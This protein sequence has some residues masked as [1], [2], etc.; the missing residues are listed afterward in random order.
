MLVLTSDRG[1]D[2]PHFAVLFGLGMIGAEIF[3]SL[4]QHG[5]TVI[6]RAS[7]DWVGPA[8]RDRQLAEL[9]HD[10]EAARAFDALLSVVWSAGATDFS[11]GREALE[12]E[13]EHFAAVLNLV[14]R[15]ARESTK[16]AASFHFISS[17]GGLFEGQRLVSGASKPAPKRPY[18]ALKLQQEREL[19]QHASTLTVRIYRPSSVYGHRV[20]RNPGKGLINNLLVNAGKG[21]QTILD[22]KLL[23]LR[24]YVYAGDVGRFVADRLVTDAAGCGCRNYL[25]ATG[26]PASILEISRLVERVS[27]KPVLFR[28]D[29]SFGNHENM[30]FHHAALPAGWS[31]ISVD[32]GIRRLWTE[33]GRTSRSEAL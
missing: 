1:L 21:V 27:R 18:G 5:F 6:R 10:L 3:R 15:L 12:A 28:L 2:R 14:D 31:P 29:D 20:R 4:R 30:T 32:A 22:A 23:A 25:L 16:G 33:V 24:D 9:A 11:S 26:R 7:L 19:E 13:Q 17:A 8:A